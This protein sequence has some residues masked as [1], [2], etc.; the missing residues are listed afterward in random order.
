MAGSHS[1]FVQ[2][3]LPYSDNRDED[4]KANSIKLGRIL[5]STGTEESYHD[6]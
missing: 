3:I 5:R 1:H 6:N 4:V 2:G